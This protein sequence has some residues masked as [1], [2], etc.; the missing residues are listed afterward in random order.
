[1]E[2]LCLDAEDLL[3]CAVKLKNFRR[4]QDL[5]MRVGIVEPLVR[6]LE[7]TKSYLIFWSKCKTF[8]ASDGA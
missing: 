8:E 5:G 2:S 3:G 4:F 1:M 6:A 7:N